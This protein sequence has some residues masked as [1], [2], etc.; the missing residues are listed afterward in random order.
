MNV[1]LLFKI[2]GIGIIAAILQIILDQAQK[3]E[4]AWM[5]TVIGVIAA[6]GVDIQLIGQLFNNVKSVFQL[7]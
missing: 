4:Y 5:V 6:L 1:D 2:A 7:W 3:K